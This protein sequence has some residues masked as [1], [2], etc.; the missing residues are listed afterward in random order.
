MSLASRREVVERLRRRYARAGR[1]YKK[2]LLDQLCELCGYERKYA[3]KLLNRPCPP[4][5]RPP[6]PIPRYGQVEREV[7][8]AIWRRA[9][10][11]C[12]KRLKAALPL[13]LPHY[14][15]RYGPL[16]RRVQRNLRDISPATIDRLLKPLRVRLGGRGRALTRPGTLLKSQIPVRAEPW[17]VSEPGFLE[18]DSVAHCGGSMAGDF[19]WSIT[20]TD[21]FSAWTACRAVWNRGAQGVVS[22]T[23]EVEQ[24]LPFPIKG[25]DCD[26][27]AE[28][29]NHHLWS[30]FAQRKEPVRFTRSRPYH[31]D[32]Q[33]HVEQKNWTHVR[34][35]LGYERLEDPALLELINDLYRNEWSWLQNFFSPSAKLLSKHR[36]RSRWVKTY[37]EPQTPYQRLLAWGGLS[38]QQRRRLKELYEGL[39]P[40]ELAESIERK[41]LK[42]FARITKRPVLK[43]S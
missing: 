31:K 24:D 21:I 42:I 36:D 8:L 22:Q 4:R 10:Q 2:K 12:S 43:V 16:A 41:L 38:R 30:Y 27:G 39:D 23:L 7:L 1:Q 5:Q 11:P 18:A 6:G 35:L 32:D 20:Y 37:D 28:F 13:W 40:F 9:E 34:Q 19:I 14:Q 33:A 26:N 15:R 25:F 3:I 17:D 29:L